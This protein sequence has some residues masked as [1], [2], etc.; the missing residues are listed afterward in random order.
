MKSLDFLFFILS[1]ASLEAKQSISYESLVPDFEVIFEDKA[2]DYAKGLTSNEKELFLRSSKVDASTIELLEAIKEP[3]GYAR[4][5]E[6]ANEILRSKGFS[7]NIVQLYYNIF[8][9]MPRLGEFLNPQK[10]GGMRR[11][12]QEAAQ[13]FHRFSSADRRRLLEANG[14][15]VEMLEEIFR[16]NVAESVDEVIFEKMFAL[17]IRPKYQRDFFERVVKPELK[18]V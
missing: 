15:L 1:W 7:E 14:D 9:L 17:L 2:P 16:L 6:L 10:S 4:T 18:T 11:A 12:L 3:H 5:M 8:V 13:L